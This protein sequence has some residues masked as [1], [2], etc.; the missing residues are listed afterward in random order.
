MALGTFDAPLFAK[1]T[2]FI[3]E[4]SGLDDAFDLLDEWP[5]DQRDLAFEAVV[6]SVREA[7]CGSRPVAFA[8]EDFKRFLK[9]N[10]MLANV[11][12]IPV[13]LRNNRDRNIGGH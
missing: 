1:R 11:E 2:Y 13:Q 12:E 6:K 5:A 4:I 9:R 3:Q 7:A 10:N 8:R